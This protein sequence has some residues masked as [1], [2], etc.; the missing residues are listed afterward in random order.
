MHC[1]FLRLLALCLWV[2]FSANS[3]A[4]ERR[5]NVVVLYVDDLGWKDI[6]CYGGPVNRLRRSIVL[7]QVAF[8]LRTFIPV[9]VSVL[10]LEQRRLPAGT[11][12]A[13]V[14]IM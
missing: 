13:P 4:A 11:T 5:P 14:C 3:F 6:G 2:A 12:Y 10:P 8:A 7:P 1:P 9:V